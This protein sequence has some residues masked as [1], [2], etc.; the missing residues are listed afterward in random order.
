MTVTIGGVN[1]PVNGFP[2][3]L[4]GTVYAI[5]EAD[6]VGGDIVVIRH[7]GV[8]VIV[9]ERRK[10]YH[11]MREFENVRL[12]P[13][14]HDITVVKIGYLEPELRE[15]ASAAFL[16]LTPGAVNQDIPSLPFARLRRPIFPLD[17]DMAEPDLTATVFAPI[18]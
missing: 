16:A 13:R 15:V 11:H 12:H 18:A 3:E 6:P 9:P 14:D 8:H 2:L 1:D 4:T 7:G 10:P 17:P 5:H